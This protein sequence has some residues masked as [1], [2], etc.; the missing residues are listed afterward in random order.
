[1][2]SPVSW[3]LFHVSNVLDL[4]YLDILEIPTYVHPHHSRTFIC[5][6]NA[7][8]FFVAGHETTATAAS[9]CLYAL[10]QAPNVQSKLRAELRSVDTDIPDMDELVALPYLD[11]VV[12]ET[13]RLHAPVPS[14]IRIATKDDMIPLQEPVTDRNGNT[15]DHIKWV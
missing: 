2:S 9:W 14:T 6:H 3:S 10:T 12:R 4:D 1:M 5:V 7:S 13:L 15:C 8:S 11:A